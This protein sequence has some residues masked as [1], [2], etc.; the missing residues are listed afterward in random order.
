MRTK[1]AYFGRVLPS[2]SRLIFVNVYLLLVELRY[3]CMNLLP[4][5]TC[6]PVLYHVGLAFDLMLRPFFPECVM[7]TDLWSFEHPSVILFC[8]ELTTT[9]NYSSSI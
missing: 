6:F 7:S 4:R 9:C 1:N 8:L 2:M 5:L 3:N